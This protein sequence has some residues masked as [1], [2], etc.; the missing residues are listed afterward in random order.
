MAGLNNWLGDCLLAKIYQKWYVVH[1]IIK[2]RKSKT[3]YCIT[4]QYKT[5]A[6]NLQLLSNA[7][8][9][10]KNHR[11]STMFVVKNVRN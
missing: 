8:T 10:Q 9:I 6:N 3:I 11:Q 1:V 4:Y 5:K 2:Y 7:L